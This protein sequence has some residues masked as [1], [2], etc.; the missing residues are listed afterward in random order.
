VVSAANPLIQPIAAPNTTPAT[1][2][3]PLNNHNLQLATL[4]GCRAT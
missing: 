4:A 2:E 1:Q 3:L